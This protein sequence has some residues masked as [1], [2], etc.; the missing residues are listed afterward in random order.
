MSVVSSFFK[1]SQVLRGVHTHLMVE[2]GLPNWGSYLIFAFATIIA[3]AF[4]GCILVCVIDF[5]YPPK[6]VS[7]HKQT[8][9]ADSKP[10]ISEEILVNFECYYCLN[11][12]ET[13]LFCRLMK[14][15]EMIC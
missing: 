7:R 8:D 12:S 3:G 14:I 1:L 13:R 4:L 5:V 2:Y 11:T 10:K 15:L 6:Y 9:G